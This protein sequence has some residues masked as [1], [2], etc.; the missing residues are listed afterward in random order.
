MRVAFAFNKL[1]KKARRTAKDRLGGLSHDTTSAVCPERRAGIARLHASPNNSFAKHRLP[2]W[3]GSAFGV[4][5]RG[6]TGFQACLGLFQQSARRGASRGRAQQ[7]AAALTCAFIFSGQALADD[8]RV[9]IS[10]AF[11]STYNELASAFE[12]ASHNRLITLPG[13]SMGTT[14]NAIPVRLQRGEDADVVIVARS[15]LDELAGK[16]FIRADSETDLARSIIGVAVR[17]GAAAPDISTVAA[18]KNALLQAKSIAYSDSASGVYVSNEL[19]RNLGIAELVAPKAQKIEATP[20]G[21][22]V[23]AGKAELGFQQM[24]ELLPVRGIT[25]V[26]PL[27]AEVQR[28]TVFSAG[29]ATRSRSPA[30]ARALIQALSS[31]EAYS[32]MKTK[33]LEPISTAAK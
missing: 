6:G 4:C 5:R 19:F 27:P 2:G 18:L 11:F 24:S 16:G 15:A 31:P 21:E 32:V 25:V 14:T 1:L 8:V 20:V 28:V 9:M 12:R 23:A 26:G 33:G 17:A 30:A 3:L 22:I 7:I 29:I 10:G 13:P